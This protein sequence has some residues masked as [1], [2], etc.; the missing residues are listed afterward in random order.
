VLGTQETQH[1]AHAREATVQSYHL[2]SKPWMG[3]GCWVLGAGVQSSNLL[4]PLLL[5]TPLPTVV[6]CAGV[7]A[8]SRQR[9][10]W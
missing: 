10:V 7:S 6:S 2:E 1:T 5:T 9:H 4:C 3:A 8:P